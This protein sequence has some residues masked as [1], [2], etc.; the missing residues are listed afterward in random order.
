MLNNQFKDNLC[1]Q[2]LHAMLF[3]FLLLSGYVLIGQHPEVDLTSI[4]SNRLQ[5]NKRSMYVLGGWAVT[6]IAVGT[7]MRGR[8]QGST[9]YFHEGNAAWNLVNLALAGG[10]LWAASGADPA[11][12]DAIQTIT[13]QQKI[14]KLLL[15]NAGLDL[16]YMA[17]GLY[18]MERSR[19][20][21]GVKF[22]RLKGYGQALLLQG[23]FL[24]VFDLTVF[25]LHNSQANPALQQI[26]SSVYV[27][28]DG[29]G[30]SLR[31]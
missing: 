10:S 20:G 25:A 26:L 15:F 18:L 30:M 31:F 24:F 7:Y 17:S 19:R 23:G 14:E 28:G 21:T 5:L 3:L 13:E 11:A 22:D 8:T 2:P 6:N 1:W 12:F 9:R 27:T 16:G 4:N 29:L